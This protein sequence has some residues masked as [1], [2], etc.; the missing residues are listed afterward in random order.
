MREMDF[1]EHSLKIL[2]LQK[3]RYYNECQLR[4]IGFFLKNAKTYKNQC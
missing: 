1:S 3:N 2:D 4:R